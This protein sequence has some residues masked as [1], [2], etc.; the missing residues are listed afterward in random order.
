MKTS[1]K[2]HPEFTGISII[3][4]IC[5]VAAG[6]HDEWKLAASF[7]WFVILDFALCAFWQWLKWR[8]QS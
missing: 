7:I 1:W 6:V 2:Y 5:F 3:A 8:K 4:A